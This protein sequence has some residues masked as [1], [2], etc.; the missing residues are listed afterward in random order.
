MILAQGIGAVNIRMKRFIYD[1][2]VLTAGPP[3]P[4]MG[5]NRMLTGKPEAF[6]FWS[7]KDRMPFSV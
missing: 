2:K 4:T 1:R 7:A 3:G 5:I 6:D